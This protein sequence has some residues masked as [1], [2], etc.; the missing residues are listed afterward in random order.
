[1]ANTVIP[2]RTPAIEVACSCGRHLRL[3]NKL[4]GRQ[5]DCPK[6]GRTLSIPAMGV[7]AEPA[8]VLPVAPTPSLKTP[9]A[10][11]KRA[12]V[13]TGPLLGAAVAVVAL[14]V[15]GW[16]YWE[17]TE[18]PSPTEN[19]PAPASAAEPAPAVESSS[20]A[21]LAWKLE[22]GK[23]I[24]LEMKTEGSKSTTTQGKTSSEEWQQTFYFRWLP[25][26]QG[27]GTWIL[28]MTLQGCTVDLRTGIHAL[29]FDTT[30][31]NDHPLSEILVGA[32]FQVRLDA[33]LKV[34]ELSGSRRLLNHLDDAEPPLRAVFETS[35][36]D[37]ALTQLVE[38]FF[39]AL[40]G[41]EASPGDTWGRQTESPAL[42]GGHFQARYKYCYLGRRKGLDR[43]QVDAPHTFHYPEAEPDAAVRVVKANLNPT[44]SG[45]LWFDPVHGRITS[46]NMNFR[47]QGEVEM[48]IA[49]DR[50]AVAIESSKKTSVRMSGE[51]LVPSAR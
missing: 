51:S 5:V 29:H 3:T 43:I 44:Q 10:P 48:D 12:A 36:N 14:G 26:R 33:D 49:G 35:F 20:P 39:A 34:R 41:R 2:P 18:R 31:K 6:C 8:L 23:P 28:Q 15:G 47:L 17:R 21:L 50:A 27:D 45:V 13:G 22:T 19:H 16:I 1:M 46:G 25:E 4:A 32:E 7:L 24:F 38:G 40:P 42:L 37:F 9:I 30:R 11:S